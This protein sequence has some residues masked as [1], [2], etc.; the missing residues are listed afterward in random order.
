MNLTLPSPKAC[1][2]IAAGTVLHSIEA[3]PER[4]GGVLAARPRGRTLGAG[5]VLLGIGSNFFALSALAATEGRDAQLSG[6]SMRDLPGSANTSRGAAAQ[7][8]P[9]SGADTTL[10]V[11]LAPDARGP[12]PP[13]ITLPASQV[14]GA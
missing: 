11:I 12:L 1:A 9:C 4:G 5:L 6:S 13:A 10:R 2:T 8:N 14:P 7:M 3:R